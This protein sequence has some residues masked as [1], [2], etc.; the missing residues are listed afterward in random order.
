MME[1]TDPDAEEEED[2]QGDDDGPT[3]AQLLEADAR[4]A[5]AAASRKERAGG[6]AGQLEQIGEDLNDDEDEDGLEDPV[7]EETDPEGSLDLSLSFL[8]L[9]EPFPLQT[10]YFLRKNCS[11]CTS[12]ES[13]QG[14]RLRMQLSLI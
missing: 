11:S 12:R 7:A 3:E 4:L 8:S 5:A 1:D 10:D 2:D 9:T 6:L 13:L 14:T